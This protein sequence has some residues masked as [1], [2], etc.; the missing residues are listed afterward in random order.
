MRIVTLAERPDLDG[1]AWA[2]PN[3][4]PEFM[5]QDPVA[6]RLFGGVPRRWPQWQLIGLAPGPD[7][8]EQVVALLRA[9]AFGW[10]GD[11][12]SLPDRGWDG[13]LERAVADRVAGRPQTAVSLLEAT[14]HPAR[15]GEGLSQDLVGAARA[16]CRAAGVLDL[17]GPVRPSGKWREPRT[18]IDDYARRVRADGLPADP[19]LRV[20]ARLGGR[21]VRVCPVSMTIPG[22]LDE[23][24]AWTGLPFDESGDVEV[25]QAL[26]PV[27]VDVEAGH[28]V[29]V[30]PNVWMHHDLR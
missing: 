17:F 2:L 4:W 7:G 18:P 9:V 28:A 5:L 15:Q 11:L 1:A 29:Y 14:V 13:V 6:E 24:R 26:C 12:A 22:T 21:I 20:H 27:H 10:D 16:A 30:E 8:V 19:W 3:S 25:P 23:W